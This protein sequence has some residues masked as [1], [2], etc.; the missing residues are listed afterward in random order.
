MGKIK[1]IE[2]TAFEK[3]VLKEVLKIPLGK[4]RTYKWIAK[5]IGKPKAVR[6]VANV[7]RKN[8][9]TLFIPC[10]R[11]IRSDGKI[12]GYSLGK[13]VKV[14]LIELEKKIKELIK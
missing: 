12:G 2:F 4:V 7:L 13:G 3:R 6:A 8:P 1:S 14:K 10:H 5:R 9:Y 11:V